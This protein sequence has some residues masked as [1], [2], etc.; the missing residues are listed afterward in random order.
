MYTRET[1]RPTN[2][3]GGRNTSDTQLFIE[4]RATMN[5]ELMVRL[6]RSTDDVTALFRE[7][8][9]LLFSVKPRIWMHDPHLIRYVAIN[10][11]SLWILEN[12]PLYRFRRDRSQLST[13]DK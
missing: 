4:A 6:F 12:K 1:F 2:I 8:K 3:E 11:V 5:I 9:K 13:P 10:Q 7:D